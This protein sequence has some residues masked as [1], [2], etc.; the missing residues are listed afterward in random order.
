MSDIKKFRK[1][2]VS[3]LPVALGSSPELSAFTVSLALPVFRD[4]FFGLV[5][6]H[7]ACRVQPKRTQVKAQYWGNLKIARLEGIPASSIICMVC[8]MMVVLK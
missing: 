2:G 5:S 6:T 1:N 7:L 8:L 4:F 3:R